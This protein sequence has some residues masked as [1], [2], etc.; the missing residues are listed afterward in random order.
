MLSMLNMHIMLAEKMTKRTAHR[1]FFLGQEVRAIIII[2]AYV[3]P[4]A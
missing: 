4:T 2:I 3:Y 1:E